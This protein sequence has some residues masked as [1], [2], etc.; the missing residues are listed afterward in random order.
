MGV[1][2]PLPPPRNIHFLTE[3]S[4]RANTNRE[5]HRL[6]DRDAQLLLSSLLQ[7]ARDELRHVKDVLDSSHGDVILSRWKK[8]SHAKR[9]KLPNTAAPDIYRSPSCE[10][11]D[12]ITPLDP[13]IEVCHAAIPSRD[14]NG[15]A[16]DLMKLL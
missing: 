13:E 4:Q 8:L 1:F 5:Y 14:T 11:A 2:E 10:P 16:R 3:G 15:F 7:Q 6:N 12:F 9:A